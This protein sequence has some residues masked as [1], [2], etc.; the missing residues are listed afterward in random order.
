M[1]H[2]R[3]AGVEGIQRILRL[4]AIDERLKQLDSEKLQISKKSLVI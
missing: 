1:L 3:V 2:D 4:K